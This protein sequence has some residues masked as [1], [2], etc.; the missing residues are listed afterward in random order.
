MAGWRQQNVTSD[1]QFYLPVTGI[2]SD[3]SV[4]L[5]V[6]GVPVTN[7]RLVYIAVTGIPH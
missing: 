5:P 6:A 4:N 2:T 7:N 3:R 1:K